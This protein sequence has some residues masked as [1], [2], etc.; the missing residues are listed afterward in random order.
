MARLN[1]TELEQDLTLPG[2]ARGPLP[3]G[4][5]NGQERGGVGQI[6]PI[7]NVNEGRSLSRQ[8]VRIATGVYGEIPTAESDFRHLGG[9]SFVEQSVSCA[10]MSWVRSPS[11]S[12][13]PSD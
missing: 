13:R 8:S 2:G 5:R 6:F 1:L 9:H 12:V 10:A 3:A 7:W 11:P 4:G